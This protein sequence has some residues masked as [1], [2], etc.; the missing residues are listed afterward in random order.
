M[1]IAVIGAGGRV[2][3]PFSLL[4]AE[5]GH[6]VLGFDINKGT[7]DLLNIE[8]KMPFK[9]EDAQGLLERMITDSMFRKKRLGFTTTSIMDH[10]DKEFDMFV[11]ILGT[12][13]DEEGNPV[14]D[15]LIDEF[16]VLKNYLDKIHRKDYRPTIMLRSTV[17]P[18]TTETLNEILGTNNFDLYFVPE[19]VLQGKSLTETVNHR[20]MI[21][22][23]E[24]KDEDDKILI[25]F[26]NS[27]KIQHWSFM[28]WKEAEVGKLM[29]NMYRYMNFA[30]AN[31]MYMI[32]NHHGIDTHK[33]IESFNYN[34]P[35]LDVPLPGPNVGGPCL[36]KDGKFLT[37][38]IPY[39]D[40]IDVA[41]QIN[42]GMPEY[43]MNMLLERSSI[44]V[45]NV[46]ILGGT[47]KANCDDTR[48]S[49]S[50]KLAK[51]LKRRGV[52]YHIHDPYFDATKYNKTSGFDAVVLMTPHDE[53]NDD[54]FEQL[55]KLR[56]AKQ[57][58]LVV[59]VWK[60]SSQSRATKDG[61]WK[62]KTE[63]EV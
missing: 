20:W 42:E 33:V 30:F 7:V 27:L 15:Y 51:C 59:D 52:K 31:E 62:Q 43:V 5:A 28:S 50:Y 57:D 14:L 25:D 23:S 45:K 29:T 21:G 46:L 9:E 6:D 41:F 11:Y 53:F 18:G 36:F 47:F 56:I 34:Y 1:E 37:Q 63:S 2:G 61:V 55:F 17:A 39:A 54:F 32:G 3:L 48:N 49:L 38:H 16:H 12:P 10:V 40:L 26:M 8:Q 35:R 44:P 60:K 19:R 13:V 58:A 4:C 22:Q 24:E